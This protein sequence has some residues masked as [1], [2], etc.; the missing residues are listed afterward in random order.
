MKEIIKEGKNILKRSLEKRKNLRKEMTKF[1]R[2][3][4]SIIAIFGSILIV[5]IL[6]SVFSFGAFEFGLGLMVLI[7][8]ILVPLSL[9]HARIYKKALNKYK[10]KKTKQRLKFCMY[11]GGKLD[12][13]QNFCPFCG[14]QFDND[15]KLITKTTEIEKNIQDKYYKKGKPLPEQ[16]EII[17][18]SRKSMYKLLFITFYSL[19]VGFYALINIL[20]GFGNILRSIFIFLEILLIMTLFMMIMGYMINAGF[21][22][23]RFLFTDEDIELYIEKRLYFQKKWADIKTIEIYKVL[24]HGYFLKI[25][26][27]NSYKI[28]S[29]KFCD[30]TKKKQKEIINNFFQFFQFSED[31][32]NQISVMKTSIPILDEEGMKS[33][34]EEIYTFA[35]AQRFIFKKY[36]KSL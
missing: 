27:S 19:M 28:I 2:V 24:F 9:I 6:L 33:L 4:D 21:I 3:Y 26:L 32:K 22:C 11:C 23:S 29:L 17:N 13:F 31:L 34:Y 18:F 12:A 35:R 15:V 8:I 1:G 16:I 25:N 36:K 20:F 7:F 30:F 14:K 5:I 10:E